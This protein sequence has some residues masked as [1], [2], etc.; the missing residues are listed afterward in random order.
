DFSA[1]VD[2]LTSGDRRRIRAALRPPLDPRLIGLVVPLLGDDGLGRA[3]RRALRQAAPQRV[4]QLVDAMLDPEMHPTVRRRLPD[5][6]G[7]VTS[8]R[9]AQGLFAGLDA[10]LP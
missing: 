10:D 4:G 1:A 6:V 7:A 2:D 8:R 5:V 3:A 9:A